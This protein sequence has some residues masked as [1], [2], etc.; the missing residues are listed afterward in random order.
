MALSYKARRR[1]AL[2]ILLIGMPIYIV[3]AVTIVNRVDLSA[4][5]KLVQFLVYVVL[6]VAWVLPFKPIF[7]GIG[8]A[9]PDAEDQEP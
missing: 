8:Q 3:V 1:W 7:L 4:L 6:G 5:P 9:D 2:F